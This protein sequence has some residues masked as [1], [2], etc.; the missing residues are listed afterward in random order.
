MQRAR[1]AG[2]KPYLVEANLGDKG[3]WYRIRVGRFAEKAAAEKF[4]RDV[5]RELGGRAL[6]MPAR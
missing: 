4:R 3:T 6:V 2:L 5:E 1:G